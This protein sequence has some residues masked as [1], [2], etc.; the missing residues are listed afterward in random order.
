MQE[1]T[2]AILNDPLY[3]KIHDDLV[4]LDSELLKHKK[5]EFTPEQEKFRDECFASLIN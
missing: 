4:W 2:D 1:N 3:E 5:I